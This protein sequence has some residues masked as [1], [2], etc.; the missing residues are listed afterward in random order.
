LP[1]V[2]IKLA[3]AA[4]PSICE[5]HPTEPRTAQYMINFFMSVFQYKSSV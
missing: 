5:A 4:G 1:L 2:G 3:V